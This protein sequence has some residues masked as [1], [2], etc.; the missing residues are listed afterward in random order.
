MTIRIHA[1]VAIVA[2]SLLCGCAT[3]PRFSEAGFPRSDADVDI[4]VLQREV[5]SE[6][7]SAN[8]GMA[9]AFGGAAGAVA[10]ALIAGAITNA[11]NDETEELFTPLRD[12]LI[13]FEVGKQ[14]VKR[15]KGSS[16]V[17]RLVVGA[18]P[19]VRYSERTREERFIDRPLI[20]IHPR[21]LFSYDMRSIW[22]ELQVW[23]LA[24]WKNRDSPMRGVSEW[25][26]FRWPLDGGSD[27]DREE[28]VA[29][30]LEKPP[31]GIISII[32]TGMDETV[33]MLEEHLKQGTLVFDDADMRIDIPGHGRHS[34][35]QSND[36]F[37][38]VASTNGSSAIYAVP[39][40][41]IE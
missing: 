11:K 5:A 30:W 37:T 19:V 16:A 24:P 31:A 40:H 36:E 39:D 12:H 34:V 38:W 27:L 9:A 14:F 28:A 23:E 15:I 8:P 26:R 32:E 4:L 6:A 35:W 10:G 3:S 13:D 17:D 29:A 21:V 20:T 18:D 25:Y 7:Y 41:A 22:V 33:S 1:V 2:C